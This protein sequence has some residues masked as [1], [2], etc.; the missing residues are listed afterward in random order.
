[1]VHSG[2]C[3]AAWG[4]Q[5]NQAAHWR[6][7][8][9][10]P[11]GLSAEH[12]AHGA[13]SPS[14]PW[15][16]TDEKG[17]PPSPGCRDI[18]SSDGMPRFE[19]HPSPSL[20]HTVPPVSVCVCRW[21]LAEG[22]KKKDQKKKSDRVL[23][24]AKRRRGPPRS[25]V[26]PYPHPRALAS[27]P[28]PN[29]CAPSGPHGTAPW[30]RPS[31][32]ESR[33]VIGQFRL[34]DA[35][36]PP[37]LH[38]CSRAKSCRVAPRPNRRPPLMPVWLNATFLALANA[39]GEFRRKEGICFLAPP[40]GARG[41]GRDMTAVSLVHPGL[42]ASLVL[43]RYARCLA[44]I[45][46][47]LLCPRESHMPSPQARCCMET[48]ARCGTGDRPHSRFVERAREKCTGEKT[49]LPMVQPIVQPTAVA[50]PVRFQQTEWTL[51]GS[52]T[53]SSKGKPPKKT[54]ERRHCHHRGFDPEMCV[55][56]A[57]DSHGATNK[58]AGRPR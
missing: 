52:S 56:P 30:A 14:S 57:K 8:L 25:P 40:P 28:R 1:M 36:P 2:V 44:V 58:T 42:R 24:P 12:G 43:P 39:R 11:G 49:A 20:S 53:A 21:Q 55:W 51:L 46:G 31:T 32:W 48:P 15:V 50:S 54:I 47:A 17:P 23:G 6:R 3:A 10:S 41:S 19:R 9:P 38:P 45:F 29:V 16:G 35:R 13:H 22:R 7:L 4:V 33:L 5:E 34:C 37:P 26:S 18:C 27:V